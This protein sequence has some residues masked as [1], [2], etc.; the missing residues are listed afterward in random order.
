MRRIKIL[1]TT[2]RDGEQSPGCWFSPEDRFTLACSL[3][4]MGVDVIEVGFPMASEVICDS[5]KAIA[6]SVKLSQLCCLCRTNKHDIDVAMSVLDKAKNP[7]LHIFLA[8]SDLHLEKKLEITR[9]EA[10]EQIVSAIRYAK[11]FTDDI[12]FSAEDATRSDRSF[13]SSAFSA[14]IMAGATTINIADTV[15]CAIPREIVA[16]IEYLASHVLGIDKV[17]TSVH[18]HNDLGMATANS[19]AA[20]DASIDQIECTVNGIGE[21][22][23]NAA[24]E[25]IVMAIKAREKFWGCDTAIRPDALIPLSQWVATHGGLAVQANKAIVGKNAFSH[26]SGIHVDGLLKCTDM[27]EFLDRDTLGIKELSIVLGRQSGRQSFKAYLKKMGVSLT[28]SQFESAFK[29][30][31]QLADTKPVVSRSDVLGIIQSID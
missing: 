3:E 17:S 13:L 20:L 15:G 24:L 22:A 23:G 19:L 31:E 1:D 10:L 25:E 4:A 6:S 2:L 30:F 7:R 29:L 11:Q 5:I 12:Q 27:Y 26:E 21:R 28:K 16:L 8:T 18:C 14:A 9:N